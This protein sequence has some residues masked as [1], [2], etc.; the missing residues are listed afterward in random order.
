M[1]NINWLQEYLQKVVLVI[2]SCMM[3]T[4]IFSTSLHLFSTIQ[5]SFLCLLSKNDDRE[6]LK[7]HFDSDAFFLFLSEVIR[8]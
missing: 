4:S 8:L 1:T 3:K 2:D 7:C 6:M 5:L